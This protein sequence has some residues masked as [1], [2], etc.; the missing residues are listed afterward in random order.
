MLSF[1]RLGASFLKA[2]L[3]RQFLSFLPLAR[4]AVPVCM[5]LQT[6]RALRSL[7]E[8]SCRRLDMAVAAKTW[9]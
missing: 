6:L 3:S 4:N 1:A 9:R 7:R 8:S 5:L 2:R